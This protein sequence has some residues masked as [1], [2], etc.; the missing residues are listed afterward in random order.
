MINQITL[1]EELGTNN[2][3]HLSGDLQSHLVGT[4]EKLKLWGNDEHVKVAGLFHAVYGT[5]EFELPLTTPTNR[6]YIA[7]QIGNEAEELV[8][9]YCACNRKF[10]Y[11]QI[12]LHQDVLFQDRFTDEEKVLSKKQ[13][14][15]LCEVTLANELDVV[16]RNPSMRIKHR[17]WYIDL[18]NRFEGIVSNIG[19]YEFRNTF[20]IAA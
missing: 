15:E 1:L 2:I 10:V 19:Y 17:D 5:Q 12:G 16:D 3:L 7:S 13:I 4:Y 18:F 8:Y 14:R 20:E 9:L 6:S 11:P